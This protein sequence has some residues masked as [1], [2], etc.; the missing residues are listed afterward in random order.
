MAV[1]TIAKGLAYDDDAVRTYYSHP[2]GEPE[3]V[4]LK[5]CG[6][7]RIEGYAFTM[8]GAATAASSPSPSSCALA[9]GSG[10]RRTSGLASWKTCDHHRGTGVCP[11]TMKEQRRW[12][13]RPFP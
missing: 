9:A 5:S 7:Y 12:S 10:W 4:L 1:E 8:F 6:T 3:E 13:I 2:G 11:T